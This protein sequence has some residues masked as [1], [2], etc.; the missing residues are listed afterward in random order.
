LANY[1]L[2]PNVP[3]NFYLAGPQGISVC[4][5]SAHLADRVAFAPLNVGL[6]LASGGRTWLADGEPMGQ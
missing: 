2:S 3:I 4:H 5:P 1:G 6:G